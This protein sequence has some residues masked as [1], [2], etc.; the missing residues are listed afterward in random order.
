MYKIN[1]ILTPAKF[2]TL[3]IQIILTIVVAFT[4]NDNILISLP[5]NLD[6]TSEQFGAANAS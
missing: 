6:I 5:S 4:K 2:S 3:I 1:E